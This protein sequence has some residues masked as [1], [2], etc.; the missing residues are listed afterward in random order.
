MSIIKKDWSSAEA[1][2]WTKEDFFAVV[3][4]IISFLMIF[5]GTCYAFLLESIGFLLLAIGALLIYFTFR[6]INPKLNAISADYEKKQK[7]YL[8]NLDK[9]IKWEEIDE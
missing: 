2:S 8:E 4:S 5:I 9:I 3:L 7:K 6:I 1:D